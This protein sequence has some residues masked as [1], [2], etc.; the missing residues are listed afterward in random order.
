MRP[1]EKSEAEGATPEDMARVEEIIRL[2][3]APVAS[4]EPFVVGSSLGGAEYSLR[5]G[6]N[7]GRQRKNSGVSK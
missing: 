1:N 2:L 4:I 6:M 3:E 5:S 7:E